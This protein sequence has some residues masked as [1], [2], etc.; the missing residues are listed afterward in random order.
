MATKK[1]VVKKLAK[2]AQRLKYKLRPVDIRYIIELANA[3]PRWP[4]DRI[5]DEALKPRLQSSLILGM[6]PKLQ[7]ALIKAAKRYQ[8]K[9]ADIA[10]DAIEEWLK[11][12]Q[13]LED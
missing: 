1:A 11:Q 2:K 9:I 4:I 10:Y 13:F 6:T 3:H 5:F 12:R 7:K 8:I